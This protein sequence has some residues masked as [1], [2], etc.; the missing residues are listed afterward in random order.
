V[1]AGGGRGDYPTIVAGI[2]GSEPSWDALWWACGE[3]KRLSG[4]AIAVYV[5]PC[6]DASLC[7]A[8]VTGCDVTQYT[9]AM[10]RANAE[11]AAR[12]QAELARRAAGDRG[13]ELAFVH[14]EGDA[15]R[16][17][18][19]IAEEL[20][21][22]VIAVGRSAKLRHRLAGSLGRRLLSKRDAPIIVVVP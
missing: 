9:L 13:L 1:A 11:R 15:G 12:L 8:S 6:V 7:I 4:R 3:A 22:D 17:L 14:A 18:V 21:A 5:S 16:E 20:E 19:R 10:R 2:D